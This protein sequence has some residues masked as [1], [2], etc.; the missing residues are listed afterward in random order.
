MVIIYLLIQQLD[1]FRI[2]VTERVDSDTRC[3]VEIPAVFNVPYIASFASFEHEWWADVGGDHVWCLI[4]DEA[5]GLGIC[6][7]V[8]VRYG[9]FFLDAAVMVLAVL[10]CATCIDMATNLD[11][12]LDVIR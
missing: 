12:I 1:H 2:T 11:L 7:E 10:K 4:L 6:G 8:G 9:G 5:A 3:K